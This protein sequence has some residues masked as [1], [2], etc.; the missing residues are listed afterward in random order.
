MQAIVFDRSGLPTEVLQLREVNKPVPGP[1]E[2]LV[3]MLNA[4]INQGDFLFIQ[5]LYPDP[6]KPSLP[7]QVAG[8][9][10][11]GIVVEKGAGTSLAEGSLVSVNYYSTWAEYAAIPEEWLIPLP[12][13]ATNEGGRGEND[14]SDSARLC[15]DRTA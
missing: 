6:K 11:T 10:G 7:G 2:A 1:G 15:H 4:P 14:L 5:S 8:N 13:S 12:S 3:K 9:Y